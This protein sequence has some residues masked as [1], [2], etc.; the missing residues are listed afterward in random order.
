MSPVRKKKKTSK[1]V[2]RKKTTRKTARKA[3]KKSGRKPVKKKTTKKAAKKKT[4]KKTEKKAARKATSTK[5]SKA[6]AAKAGKKA[7]TKQAGAREGAP[8][9]RVAPRRKTP[10]KTPSSPAAEIL[11]RRAPILSSETRPGL[12]TKW[13]CFSCG[14]K[15]YD[16]GKEEPLCPKCGANQHDRPREQT[17]RKA[18]SPAPARRQARGMPPLLDDDDDEPADLISDKAGELDIGLDSVEDADQDFL[19]EDESSDDDS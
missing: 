4:E 16:L 17:S 7:G 10:P 3:A 14:S 19:D 11:P 15:F 9:K 18:A 5:A 12:G 8:S 13:E 1:K 6:P 2:A